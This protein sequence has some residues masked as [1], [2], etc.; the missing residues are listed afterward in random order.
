MQQPF[1]FLLAGLAYAA[2]APAEVEL[3]NVQSGPLQE[4]ERIRVHDR[5]D[6]VTT[7]DLNGDGR[8]DIIVGGDSV[9]IWL[10]SQDGRW[11]SAQVEPYEAMAQALEFAFGDVNGDGHLDFVVAEHNA[12]EPQFLM[13]L[14]SASGSFELAPGN[15]F[16]V[17]ATPHLHTIALLDI[18]QDGHLDVLTDSW[19]ENRL[20]WVAGQGDG[21]FA[22]PGT[23]IPVPPAP[24]QNLAVGDFDGDAQLDV[25]TPAHDREA[26]TLLLLQGPGRFEQA[27]G[28]PFPSFGGFSTVACVDLNRDGHLDVL[29]VHRSDSST[30]YK[31][32]AL[33]I[34]LGDGSG[35]L[36]HAPLSPHLDLPE[37][38]NTLAH[39]DVDGDG[40][41]DVVVLGEIQKQLGLFLGSE[42]G[43]RTAGRNTVGG[44]ARGL[45]AGNVLGDA[46]AEI[47]VTDFGS[48]E[49]ILFGM[50]P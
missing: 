32:D 16:V 8:Q 30:Q 31:Q 27:P 1:A 3:E 50:E 6:A 39:G 38:S 19:P 11:L 21:K 23:Q 35:R 15:P 41:I 24:M 40:W 44:R 26:V 33:S 25:V 45:A 22:L 10:A 43:L 4:L 9:S 14:G 20:V 48:G 47:L 46:R 13:W 18:N 37:R 7:K 17:D 5:P 42:E 28:S 29:E 34:L 49:V 12:K 36:A 2:C